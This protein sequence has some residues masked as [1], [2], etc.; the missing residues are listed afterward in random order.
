MQMPFIQPRR[1]WLLL[2]CSAAAFVLMVAPAL[3]HQRPLVP[4]PS[5]GDTM[6]VHVVAYAGHQPTYTGAKTRHGICATDPAVIP[7]GTRFFVPGYGECLAA[8]IGGGV[9]GKM[10]DVWVLKE[11]TAIRW[12]V[13]HL[14]IK[15]R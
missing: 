7:L 12:G 10:V 6:K 5:R 2:V 3:A 13:K 1:R 9:R 14:T 11:R 15:F 8:D 4:S